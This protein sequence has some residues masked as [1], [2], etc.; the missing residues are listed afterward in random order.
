MQSEIAVMQTGSLVM[1]EP[2]AVSHEA[3]SRVVTAALHHPTAAAPLGLGSWITASATAVGAIAGPFS[4]IA[5][6]AVVV[7]RAAA[8]TGGTAII[9]TG[10]PIAIA[11]TATVTSGIAVATK[12]A[13]TVSPIRRS[14]P[15]GL[16]HVA[17]G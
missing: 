14:A 11:G 12:G 2:A 16:R 3:D 5:R 9:P 1:Q 8:V 17:R 10:T 13:A 4:A 7:A 15:K 6:V